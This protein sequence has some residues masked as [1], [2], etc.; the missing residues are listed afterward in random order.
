M[1]NRFKKSV[2]AIVLDGVITAEEAVLLKKVAKEENVSETES[3]IYITQELK[4]RKV[5]LDSGDNWFERNTGALITAI[6]TLGGIAIESFIDGK[7]KK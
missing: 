7:N 1:T 3:E 4:K 5:K 2:K 6:V